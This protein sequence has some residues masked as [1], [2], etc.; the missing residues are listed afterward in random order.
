MKQKIL[1]DLKMIVAFVVCINEEKRLVR[2][3]DI[4]GLNDIITSTCPTTGK[5]LV[6]QRLLEDFLVIQY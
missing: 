5:V 2:D 6:L 3:V 4:R 1:E